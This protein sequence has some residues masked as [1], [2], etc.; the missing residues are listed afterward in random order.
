MLKVKS[1]GANKVVYLSDTPPTLS[2]L[3]GNAVATEFMTSTKTKL[4][5]AA[6]RAGRYGFMY[7]SQSHFLCSKRQALESQLPKKLAT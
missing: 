2:P 1:I 6:R 4:A 3:K 7:L 5:R